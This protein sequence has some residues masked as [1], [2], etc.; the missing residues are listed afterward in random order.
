MGFAIPPRREQRAY[1]QGLDVVTTVAP[2]LHGKK[3][4]VHNSFA[5]LSGSPL[6]QSCCRTYFVDFVFNRFSE[7]II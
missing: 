5:Q 2:H 6:D 1:V 4:R 7:L 3:R